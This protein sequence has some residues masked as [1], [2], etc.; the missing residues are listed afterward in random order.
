MFRTILRVLSVVWIILIATLVVAQ[1]KGIK[2]ISTLTA[3]EGQDKWAL[4]VGINQYQDDGITDLRYAVNDAERLHQLLVDPEYG[5]F[6]SRR[7]SLLTDRTEV[8]PTRL[9]VLLALKLLEDSADADDTIFIFFS[10]H[11]I[12]NRGES[13]FLTRDTRLGLVADTAVPKSAFERT[14]SQTQ[15]KVQVMFF[16]ACHSGA[17]KDKDAGG[18]MSQ[19]L[20]DFIDD[21]QRPDP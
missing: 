11:G 9:E 8:K 13:Y 14:L 16:D 2:R 15:A 4:V 5:G 18:T 1:D 12:A 17:S 21:R 3:A 7:V 20:A 19:D 10:G 6:D